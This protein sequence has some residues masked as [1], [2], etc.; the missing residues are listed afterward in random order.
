MAVAE[1]PADERRHGFGLML[2]TAALVHVA[3]LL[4]RQPGAGWRTLVIPVVMAAQGLL[5]VIAS[6]GNRRER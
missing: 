5:L 3:L 2:L 6:R 4:V 1:R